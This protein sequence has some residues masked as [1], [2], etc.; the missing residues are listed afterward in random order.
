MCHMSL[1]MCHVSCVMCHVSCVMCHVSC[2]MCHVSCVMCHVSCV[3]CYVS[4]VIYI[5]C[6][7]RGWVGV[8]RLCYQ[9]GLPCLVLRCFSYQK[10]F[11]TKYLLILACIGLFWVIK[12]A[13]WWEFTFW[14]IGIGLECQT[15]QICAC[16]HAAPCA[17]FQK[18]DVGI[19]Q[20]FSNLDLY[21]FTWV[22]W[23]LSWLN[24][25]TKFLKVQTNCN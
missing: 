10:R 12:K 16:V 1:V 18:L 3:M 15:W 2:V 13:S 6:L 21:V 23:V 17:H 14:D 20:F 22:L 24:L 7:Q 5:F 11:D 4:H 19:N 25:I 9:Q 8:L